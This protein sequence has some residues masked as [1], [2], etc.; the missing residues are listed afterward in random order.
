MHPSYAGG[1]GNAYPLSQPRLYDLWKTYGAPSD[2][3]FARL[4]AEEGEATTE[5]L[6][7]TE[8]ADPD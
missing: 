4:L 3:V 2:E 6:R 8:R 5:R 1:Q 7:G